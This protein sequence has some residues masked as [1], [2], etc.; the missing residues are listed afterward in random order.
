MHLSCSHGSRSHSAA[1][2][3]TRL[4]AP[5]R[6]VNLCWLPLTQLESCC[7]TVRSLSKIHIFPCPSKTKP[8][9]HICSILACIRIP[10]PAAD[11]MIVTMLWCTFQALIQLC[12]TLVSDVPSVS[13]EFYSFIIWTDHYR[14]ERRN[15]HWM[16]HTPKVDHQ[17]FDW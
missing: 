1:R 2:T 3:H 8:N 13:V 7:W 16:W 4:C 12:L 14:Q 17:I 11:M 5:T 15:K 9:I 6:G 10:A